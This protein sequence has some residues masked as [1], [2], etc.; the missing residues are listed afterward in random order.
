[1]EMGYLPVV[2]QR[3]GQA[4]TPTL[5]ASVATAVVDHNR[6]LRSDGIVPIQ[7]HVTLR[8]YRCNEKSG[9]ICVSRMAQC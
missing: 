8:P 2:G 6:N 5:S 7:L 3:L 9:A 1:M 4:K